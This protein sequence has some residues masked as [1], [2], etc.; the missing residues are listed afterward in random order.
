MKKLTQEESIKRIKEAGGI[1]IGQYK[2]SHFITDF[3]CPKCNNIF[4]R[5]P[6]NVWKGQILCKKC[7]IKKQTQTQSL[8]QKEAEQKFLKVGWKL[9]SK[10]INNYKKVKAKCPFC[11][12]IIEI[13]PQNVFSKNTKSCGCTRYK[14]SAIKN[15]TAIKEKSMGH[16]HPQLIKLWSKNN[17]MSIFEVYPKGD[18][19]YLWICE[20]Y[21]HEYLMV[22]KNIINRK[23][24]CPYCSGKRTLVGFNDLASQNPE[25]TQ[26]WHSIKNKLKPTEVTCMSNKKVWWKCSKCE[27]EWKTQIC[28]R[29]NSRGCPNCYPQ[30]RTVEEIKKLLNEWDIDFIPEKSFD[31]CKD[32]RYLPFDFWLPDDNLLIEYNGSQHYKLG[33]GYYNNKEKFKKTQKHDKIKKDWVE[34][35]PDLKLLIIPYTEQDNLE[36]IIRQE[37]KL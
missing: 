33:T 12:N 31:T 8:T 18:K 22:A 28:N 7:G 16:L 3:Q 15:S 20:K 27:Y 25:L 21:K 1:L 23:D 5:S 19:K 34:K 32:K 13:K 24:G 30:S 2:D 4:Q 37:L 29:S 9:L 14:I 11:D 35:N 6:H 17:K 26:E 10:Y 36:N